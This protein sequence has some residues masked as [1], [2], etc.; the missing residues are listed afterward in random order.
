MAKKT[1][2]PAKTNEVLVIIEKDNKGECRTVN[3]LLEHV[4]QPSELMAANS[5]QAALCLNLMAGNTHADIVAAHEKH[6]GIARLFPTMANAD[7]N[8]L[9]K[10]LDSTPA[11]LQAAWAAHA[12]NV[13]RIRGISLQA[14][15]KAISE[16]KAKS[17]KISLREALATWCAEDSNKKIMDAKGFPQSLY[18]ILADYDLLGEEKEV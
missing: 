18:D 11:K 7:K 6:G 10:C 14:I 13:K 15:A 2:T 3:A 4:I 9:K 5:V 12:A 17:D 1:T 16:P 8:A